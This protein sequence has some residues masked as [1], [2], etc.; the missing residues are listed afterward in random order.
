MIELG[1][2]MELNEDTGETC[3]RFRSLE[4]EVRALEKE[5]AKAKASERD[6]GAQIA[7]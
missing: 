4:T 3:Y 1:G 5:R 7:F 6:V 2:E